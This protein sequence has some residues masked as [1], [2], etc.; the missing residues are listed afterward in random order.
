M[1]SLLATFDPPKGRHPILRADAIIAFVSKTHNVLAISRTKS[2]R[3]EPTPCFRQGPR[4]FLSVVSTRYLDRFSKALQHYCTQLHRSP[5]CVKLGSFLYESNLSHRATVVSS[6]CAGVQVRPE[7]PASE[8]ACQA[9]R[10]FETL[11]LQEDDCIGAFLARLDNPGTKE[12]A[13]K[14]AYFDG[15]APPLAVRKRQRAKL[16]ACAGEQVA[17]KVTRT[18]ENG[19]WILA[20]VQR[21]YSDTETVRFASALSLSGVAHDVC[22]VWNSSTTC[23]MMMTRANSFV[24]LGIT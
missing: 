9:A 15:Q 23:K 21:F 3:Q 11:E 5:W 18:D 1:A 8:L 10:H 20:T 14:T 6:L 12:Y 7:A 2:A 4:Q 22:C 19:S 16:A 17:A 24:S 13:R